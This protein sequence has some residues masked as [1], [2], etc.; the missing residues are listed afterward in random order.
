MKRFTLEQRGAEID[1][2]LAAGA[3]VPPVELLRNSGERRTERKRRL[4]ARL[5][6]IARGKAERR[7]EG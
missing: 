2:K 3:R 6:R 4:L 7:E 5:D 1:R